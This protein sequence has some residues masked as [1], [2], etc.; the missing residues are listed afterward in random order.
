MRKVRYREV[1][2]WLLVIF[3]CFA[4]FK[5]EVIVVKDSSPSVH[6][7][8]PDISG[9]KLGEVIKTRGSGIDE[10]VKSG[11]VFH[12]P[13]N[14]EDIKMAK[15]AVRFAEELTGEKYEGNYENLYWSDDMLKKVPGLL[16]MTVFHNG[17]KKWQA[18]V[19]I[20]SEIKPKD[21]HNLNVMRD[22]ASVLI[23]EWSHAKSFSHEIITR[24][25][26]NMVL[27]MSFD[28]FYNTPVEKFFDEKEM[29]EY[30]D[31]PYHLMLEKAAYD[32]GIPQ[33]YIY[34]RDWSGSEIGG[35]L[36]L[37]TDPSAPRIII[38]M[39]TNTNTRINR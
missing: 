17:L 15:L 8:Y 5:K 38:N 21:L 3:F 27:E 9:K 13:F 6:V 37:L 34:V 19:V 29:A 12:R 23:H 2:A 26:I 11:F 1:A 4:F 16:G 28:F 30:K 31:K 25:K 22:F 18:Y 14:K 24:Y 33:P 39:E 20:T 7:K 36:R 10:L 35:T 32:A